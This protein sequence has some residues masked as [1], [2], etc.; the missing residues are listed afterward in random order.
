[1]VGLE[2]VTAADRP[3]LIPE[4]RR[5][6]ASPWPD[7]L[8]HDE[9]VNEYWRFLYELVPDYQFAL[10]EQE[11]GGDGASLRASHPPRRGNPSEADRSI[12]PLGEGSGGDPAG[13]PPAEVGSLDQLVERVCA[14]EAG[15]RVSRLVPASRRG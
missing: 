12:V 8:N 11:G 1:V 5:L 10:L 4:I 2:I 6:G 15:P 9:V 7:F 3:D 13:K 14:R